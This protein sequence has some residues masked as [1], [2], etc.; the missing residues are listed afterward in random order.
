MVVASHNNHVALLHELIMWHCRVVAAERPCWRAFSV[1]FG[2]RSVSSLPPVQLRQ[3]TNILDDDRVKTYKKMLSRPYHI[4]ICSDEAKRKF[5]LTDDDLDELVQ[6]AIRKESPYDL[7]EDLVVQ[8]RL[9]DVVRIAK[10]KFDEDALVEHYVKYLQSSDRSFTSV[11]SRIYGAARLLTGGKPYWTIN[12]T[13][14]ALQGRE[15]VLQGLISNSV[16]CAVK[17]LVWFY[18]GS[19]AVFADLMHSSSD[20]ANYSYRLLQLSKSDQIRDFEH[21]YGYAPL[22]Y[23]TADRSFVILGFLGFFVPFSTTL[24]EIFSDTVCAAST[25]IFQGLVVPA[26]LFMTSIVLEG[27]AMRTATREMMTQANA[28]ISEQQLSNSKPWSQHVTSYVRDGSDVMSVATFC[29][30]G[31]GVIGCAMGLVGL[32]L[33]W[34]YQNPMFDLGA[35]LCMASSVGVVSVFLL[36]RTGRAL[37][38]KTLPAPRVVQIVD[39]LEN[40]HTIVAVYDV[41]TEVIGTDTVRFKAEVQ[42]NSDTITTSLLNSDTWKPLSSQ[43]AIKERLQ[44]QLNQLIPEVQKGLPCQKHAERWLLANNAIFYEALAWEL[45]KAEEVIR[46]ELVEFRNVHIDLE[47][48]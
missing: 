36:N 41:K 38:G 8:Y 4:R 9:Q 31:S 2:P 13:V 17:A 29:E 12:T 15:S 19:H 24:K 6:H 21:P 27:I 30:A 46:H 22:R 5:G 37:L 10:R 3:T 1:C 18:T 25:D 34:F 43:V 39:K 40:W 33:S 23:I 28:E 35:S 48:W 7:L 20:V 32:G 26:S 47:P 45:K 16:I 11:R 14:G 42:F 44:S